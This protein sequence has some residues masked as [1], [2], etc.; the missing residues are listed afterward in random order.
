MLGL[1][2][3]PYKATSLGAVQVSRGLHARRINVLAETYRPKRDDVIVNWGNASD[4]AHSISESVGIMLNR[5]HKVEVAVNK[6]RFLQLC[7]EAK[8]PCPTWTTDIAEAQ[9]WL[10]KH[11]VVARTVVEGSGGKGIILAGKESGQL[12]AARL[13]T[14]YRPK[15]VEFRVH[16]AGE[17]VIDAQQKKLRVGI[18]NPN[19]KIRS[20]DNGW[21]FARNNIKVPELVMKVALDTVE[22]CGL[23]FGAVD[24]GW[25]ERALK[26]TVYEVNTAPGMEGS[27][28]GT[29]IKTIR[30]IIDHYVRAR[31]NERAGKPKPNGTNKGNVQG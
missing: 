14:L 21:I 15:R 19:Y 12:P 16:V 24:I 6:I 11:E 13:Y 18:Q 26:A 2:V 4:F 25:Q 7:K 1:Y 17:R 28:V 30:G 27:T 8:L 9:E 5:P 29:Y 22:A 10:K 3:L 20:Y 23:D 31:T